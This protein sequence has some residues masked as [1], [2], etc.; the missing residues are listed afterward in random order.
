[1]L[2]KL[3]PHSANTK[4][5]E[6][7]D[8]RM[9]V[10]SMAAAAAGVSMLA[11]AKPAQAKVV[12]TPT[13]VNI[14][15]EAPYALDVN[16]DGTTD[17]TFEFY[18]ADHTILLLV[19]LDVSG[20]ALHCSVGQKS[21]AV[22][23]P[24]GAPIGP[25]QLFTTATTYGGVFMAAAFAY[26]RTSFW[27]PWAGVQNRYLGMKFLID[28]E[29]HYGW[30]RFSIDNWRN[31]GGKVQLTGYAY[32]TD[33]N[34]KIIAGDEGTGDRAAAPATSAPTAQPASLGLLARGAAA[35]PL[36]RGDATLPY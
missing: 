8:H 18:G 35:L 27:G 10:Y 4:L 34:K 13:N 26:S 5:S 2:R 19:E 23:F 28:G 9:K 11:L 30:A 12:Y 1:M 32:E 36:W 14:A 3:R 16:G 6:T 25:A 17:F 15:D 21:E 29:V 22:A 7:I 33:V 20:N 31:N 24:A